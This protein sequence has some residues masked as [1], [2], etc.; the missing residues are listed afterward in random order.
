MARAGRQRSH[1]Q[2]AGSAAG[3]PEGRRTTARPLFVW[4]TTFRGC[5]RRRPHRGATRKRGDDHLHPPPGTAAC[6]ACTGPPRTPHP[7][8]PI[9]GTGRLPANR[10]IHAPLRGPT[11]SSAPFRRSPS[12]HRDAMGHSD[13]RGRDRRAWSDMTSSRVTSKLTPGTGSASRAFDGAAV[14]AADH[15]R[16]ADGPGGVPADGAGGGHGEQPGATVGR[17]PEAPCEPQSPSGVP[18]ESR[19]VH[20]DHGRPSQDVRETV[21][22]VAKAPETEGCNG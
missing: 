4:E 11:A 16:P 10:R 14:G 15:G 19:P 9:H 22:V 7:P 1:H 17:L 12:A 3:S 2:T 8:V 18:A 13:M 20:R 5:H 21:S 6:P